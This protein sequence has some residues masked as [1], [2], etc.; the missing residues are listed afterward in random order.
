MLATSTSVAF[1]SMMC[2]MAMSTAMKTPV[3]PTPVLQCTTMGA[4]AFCAISVWHRSI[5]DRVDVGTLLLAHDVTWYCVTTCAPEEESSCKT[6]TV[7]KCQGGLVS[8]QFCIR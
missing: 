1:L 3:R 5:I 8:M 2:L 6:Q 7:R 4:V